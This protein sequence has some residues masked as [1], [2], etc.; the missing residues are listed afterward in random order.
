LE[1]YS[2]NLLRR[3]A[4]EGRLAASR[5][6]SHVHPSLW[7]ADFFGIPEK[8]SKIAFAGIKFFAGFKVEE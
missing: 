3:A 4:V 5:R 2:A 6:S 7:A 8:A 1:K